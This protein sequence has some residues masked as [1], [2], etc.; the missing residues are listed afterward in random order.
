V[1]YHLIPTTVFT[2][3]EYGC[4]GLSEE[5]ATAKIGEANVE[6]YHSALTPL[7]W[8][9]GDHRPA[10]KCYAKII[11]NKIDNNRVV[12]F[13]ILS[14]HAGEMT[15]GW[16]W[17]VACYLHTDV[18]FFFCILIFFASPPFDFSAMR[19]GASYESFITTIG[20]H[21][22]VVEEFTL[23]SISKSSGESAEKGGC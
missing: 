16:A 5:D 2:P 19:L 4:C 11:V 3:L 13:H 23:L 15:Q 6:V 7:E 14:P 8:T 1:E 18:R 22:T 12:G 21:P 9:I 10:N 20:I 17:C